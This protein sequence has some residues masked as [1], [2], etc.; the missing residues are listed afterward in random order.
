ML[1]RILAKVHAPLTEDSGRKLLYEIDLT[2]VQALDASGL[3]LLAVFFRTL[4]HHNVD[5]YCL[6][7]SDTYREKI[8]L[9]GFGNEIFAGE[10]P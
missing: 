2:G 3:Q 5:K 9:L 4:R 1:Q 7:I 8:H 10:R 6:K